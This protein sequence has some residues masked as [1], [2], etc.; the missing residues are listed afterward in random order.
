MSSSSPVHNRIKSSHEKEPI[1]IATIA[2]DRETDRQKGRGWI[3]IQDTNDKMQYLF[4]CTALVHDIVPALVSCNM[5]TKQWTLRV[6]DY[7]ETKQCYKIYRC[8]VE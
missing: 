4:L 3:L 5:T 1:F 7:M 8:K 6:G 2:I